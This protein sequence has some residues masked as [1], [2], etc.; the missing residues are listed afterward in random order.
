MNDRPTSD[1]IVAAIVFIAVI[2]LLC[3]TPDL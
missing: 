1:D 2:V 3:L